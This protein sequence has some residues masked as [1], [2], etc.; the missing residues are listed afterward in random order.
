MWRFDTTL[1]IGGS[2]FSLA[3]DHMSNERTMLSYIRTAISLASAGVGE[4]FFLCV[5]ITS[6]PSP[7]WGF[8]ITQALVDFLLF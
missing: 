6:S 2:L 7:T 3:R 5:N 4:F 1:H 8:L